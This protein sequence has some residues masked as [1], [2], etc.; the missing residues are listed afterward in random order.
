M[1]L[2]PRNGDTELKRV[3]VTLDP[4]CVVEAL[5]ITRLS[6]STR[7]RGRAWLRSLV[8]LGYL[9]EARLLC[10][11]R[12]GRADETERAYPPA[13]A[14]L[15]RSFGRPSARASADPGVQVPIGESHPAKAHTAS[16]RFA[17]LAAVMG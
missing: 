6:A 8:T 16:K 1:S 15:R 17:H 7:T 11:E 2:T 4:T 9:T 13:P 5:V 3:S 14:P 12:A 10:A